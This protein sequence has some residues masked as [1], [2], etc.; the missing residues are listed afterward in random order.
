MRN[1]RRRGGPMGQKRG[2]RE[3]G[4]EVDMGE[5][6]GGRIRKRG[7]SKKKKMYVFTLS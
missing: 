2:K 5:V 4:G 7:Q 6:G 3:E 1:G